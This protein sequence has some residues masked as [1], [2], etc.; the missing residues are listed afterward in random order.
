MTREEKLP[1]PPERDAFE[2]WCIEAGYA[3]R[4]HQ[5]FWFY[6]TGGDGMYAAWQAAREQALAECEAICNRLQRERMTYI[7]HEDDLGS[8]PF[9][10]WV[11][12]D[13]ADAIRALKGQK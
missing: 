1:P 13:C 7:D 9:S 2:K 11:P 5:G 6:R 12:K 10:P 4:N 8:I 3:Y